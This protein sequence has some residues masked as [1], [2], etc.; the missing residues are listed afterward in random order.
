MSASLIEPFLSLEDPRIDRN[1]STNSSTVAQGANYALRLK[2]NQR[3]LQDAVAFFW[4]VAQAADLAHVV[5]H[6]F[7][8]ELVNTG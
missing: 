1:K 8:E 7:T 3:I 5:V 6:D 4:R 2:G